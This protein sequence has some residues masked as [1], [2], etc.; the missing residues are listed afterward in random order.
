MCIRDS[1]KC[2]PS[3]IAVLENPDGQLGDIHPFAVNIEITE[4]AELEQFE[5]WD[6]DA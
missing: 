3:V 5:E 4:F 6:D 2:E 1:A